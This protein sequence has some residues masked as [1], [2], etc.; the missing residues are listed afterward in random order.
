MKGGLRETEQADAPTTEVDAAPTSGGVPAGLTSPAALMALQR[1]I[2]NRAC[3]RMLQRDPEPAAAP[4]IP[5]VG[6]RAQKEYEFKIE[7]SALKND[8]AS[9]S[10]RFAVIR[11][12]KGLKVKNEDMS[13]TVAPFKTT[14]TAGGGKLTRSLALA[15]AKADWTLWEPW[16]GV[17]FQGDLKALEAKL[18]EGKVD[19]N[20]L[21]VALQGSGTI[22]R[23]TPDEGLGALARWCS[24]PRSMSAW[25]SSSPGASRSR[26]ILTT[27]SS[28]PASPRTRAFRRRRP[29]RRPSSGR[30]STGSRAR[31]SRTSGS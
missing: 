25:R 17:K 2:G 30:A 28:S 3:A 22:D 10:F 6:E 9:F 12:V 13:A 4:L 23:N 31:C 7:P 29:S 24:S 14:L 11:D 19:V 5:V 16:K 1:R 27:R 8:R 26:S 20:A 15:A 18:E 21:V